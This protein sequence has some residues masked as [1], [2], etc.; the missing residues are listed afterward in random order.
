MAAGTFEL[1]SGREH[2]VKKTLIKNMFAR[3]Q[4]KQIVFSDEGQTRPLAQQSVM[5]EIILKE[6]E[7]PPQG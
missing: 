1:S 3:P 6:V 7:I 4:F 5:A 2:G